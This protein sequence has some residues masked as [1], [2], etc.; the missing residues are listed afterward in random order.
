[1]SKIIILL[2]LPGSGKGTQGEF[3]A[4]K[5]SF[6][7]ISTGEIF[8]NMAA[9]ESEEAR[10]LNN[11]LTSGKLVSDQ[12]VNEIVEKFL[13]TNIETGYILDGYPRTMKQADYFF[14]HSQAEIYTIFFDIDKDLVLERIEARFSCAGCGKIYNKIFSLPR[15]PG[16]CDQCGSIQFNF[17]SDDKTEIIKNRIDEYIKNTL[18]IISIC[19]EKGKLFTI[20]AAKSKEEIS[21]S[22]AKIIKNI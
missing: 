21:I 1:M 17:R 15:K 11:Y 3:I 18:P 7:H 13:R 2:G 16:I 14:A 6:T 19:Q 4:K 9:G 5:S 12:L 8:R 20:D 10:L 22:L